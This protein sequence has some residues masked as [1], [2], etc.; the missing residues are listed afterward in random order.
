MS[1]SAGEKTEEATPK[2]QEEAVKKGQIPK[3][4]EIQTVFVLGSAMTALSI[5]GHEMWERLSGTYRGILGHLHEW[6]VSF[7]TMHGYF[8]NALGVIATTVAPVAVTTVTAALVAGAI[9]SRFRT[10]SEA[11]QINWE[12]LNPVSGLQRIFSLKSTVPTLVGMFKLTIIVGLSYSAVQ[13]IISDPIFYTTVDSVRIADFMVDSAYRIMSRVGGAMVLIAAGD[14][15]YQ[16]WRNK[17]DMM[18]SKSEVK[19]ETKSSEGDP[20]VKNQRRR[21]QMELRRKKSLQDVPKADVVITNP[22]HFAIALQYDRG[23]MAA[24]KILAKGMRKNALKIKEI[25][26]QNG[27]PMVENRP[28]ARMLYKH[29]KVGGEIP[30]DLFAAVAE[31]LAWVYR[32]NPYRYYRKN[33]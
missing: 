23:S 11:I 12:K 13:T 30:A 17:K 16:I 5:F 3:S 8:L 2:R 6:E 25:A 20:E 10:A 33:Q 27:V 7:D 22:T 32:Q 28:L 1:E 26:R 4:Q 18:M 24:P 21:M 14:Y 9:Q 31:V 15:A 29:G 19:D